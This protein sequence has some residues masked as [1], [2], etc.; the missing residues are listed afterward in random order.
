MFLKGIQHKTNIIK[1]IYTHKC[2]HSYRYKYIYLNQSFLWLPNSHFPITSFLTSL[3]SYF[4]RKT[5]ANIKNF[6]IPFSLCLL[7][8]SFPLLSLFLLLRPSN[9][10]PVS[11]TKNKSKIESSKT[12]R[13]SHDC[14][15]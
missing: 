11:Y 13:L 6:S 3:F 8:P 15:L 2:T 4:S 1:Y 7:F 5:M 9:T 10:F 12:N 14:H